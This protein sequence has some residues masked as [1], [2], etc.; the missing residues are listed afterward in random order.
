MLREA[1]SH[2]AF[3]GP[4]TQNI[5]PLAPSF[6]QLD[7]ILSWHLNLSRP[8]F[9]TFRQDQS[10]VSI[11]HNFLYQCYLLCKPWSLFLTLSDRDL[12]CDKTGPA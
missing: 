7:H 1:I 9:L 6:I 2:G 5:T 3:S 11:S 12:F 10:F 8:S 4:E